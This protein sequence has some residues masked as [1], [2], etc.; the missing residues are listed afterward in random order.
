MRIFFQYFIQFPSEKAHKEDGSLRIRAC[1]RGWASP[2]LNCKF[3]Q[4]PFCCF[5][6]MK[7]RGE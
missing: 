6:K 4:P 2:L 7:Y 3:L 1:G 5:A